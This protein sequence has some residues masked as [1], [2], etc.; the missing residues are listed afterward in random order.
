ML[1]RFLKVLPPASIL[2]PGDPDPRLPMPAENVA[3]FEEAMRAF[4]G[5]TFGT[6]ATVSPQVRL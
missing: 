4:P 5:G 2:L 3:G 1:E 6:H